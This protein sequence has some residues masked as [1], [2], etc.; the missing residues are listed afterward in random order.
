VLLDRRY[1]RR[2]YSGIEGP[3]ICELGD[4]DPATREFSELAKLSS[5]DRSP[6]LGHDLAWPDPVN[7]AG[8][9][10]EWVPASFCA[11]WHI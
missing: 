5:K 11:T 3:E 9:H 7:E 1:L 8:T 2:I 10:S 4:P 6:S